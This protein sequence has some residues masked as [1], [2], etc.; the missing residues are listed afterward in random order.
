MYLQGRS[1]DADIENRL[2]TQQE[3]ERVEWIERVALK[4][5]RKRDS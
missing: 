1:R 3:K 4:H 5:P 2:W